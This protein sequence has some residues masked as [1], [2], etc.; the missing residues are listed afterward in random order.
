MFY[1]PR[2]T[3]YRQLVYVLF[4]ALVSQRVFSQSEDWQ[5]LYNQAL[6]KYQSE[7]FQNSLQS[8]EGALKVAGTISTLNRA[9]TIQLITASCVALANPDNGLKYIEEEI[10]LFQQVEGDKSK[11]LAEALKKQIVFL[12]Q[13]NQLKAAFEKS[14]SVSTLF[15]DSYGPNALQ[16]LQFNILWGDLA[17]AN[18]DTLKARQLWSKCIPLLANNP[19][20]K[21]DYK[22]VMYNTADLEEKQKDKS[23]A[24][25]RY[26]DLI[27]FLEKENQTDDP[28]YESA[29][30]NLQG[31]QRIPT[32]SASSE[33]QLLI[34][35]A[36][37]FQSQN[38]FSEAA[39]VYNR[40]LEITKQQKTQDKLSFSV[41]FNYARLLIDHESLRE[42]NQ[43]LLEARSR[44][45][46][47]FK[48]GDLE[49]FLI[50]LTEADFALVLGQKKEAIVKYNS[51]VSQAKDQLKGLSYLLSSA[52]QLL[53]R[54]LPMP[55]AKLLKPVVAS[56]GLNSSEFFEKAA[57]SYSDAL[58][59]LNKPDSLLLFLSQPVFGN[60]RWAEFKKVEALQLQGQWA[61]AL[62]K[63]SK[64]KGLTSV[65]DR[66]KG[67][68]A[69]HSAE[70]A[71]QMGDYIV[72]ED[73]YLKAQK[74]LEAVSPLD[75]WQV[76]NS[77]AILYSRMG[78][79]DKSQKIL[80]ALLEKVPERHPLHLTAL[81]NLS[82]TYIDTN[83]LEKAKGIQEKIISIEKERVGEAHPDY[84]QAISNLAVLYQKSGRYEAAKNLLEKALAISKDNFGEQSLDFVLKESISG[85]V[86]K[87]AGEVARAKVSL[88]HAERVLSEKLGAA[89]PDYVSC[90]YN[91]AMVFLRTGD[92]SNALPLMEHLASFYKKKILEFFP[93]MNEQEQV[94]LYNKINNAVQDFQQF[95]VEYGDRYPALI[96]HLFDFRLATK[97]LLLNSSTKTRELILQRGDP[98]LKA[99]FLSWIS[100][101]DQIGKLY[102]SDQGPFATSQI[103]RL[104]AQANELEK[105]MSQSSAIFKKN[106]AE[107]DATWSKIH[108]ML[109]EGEAAVEFIR[110]KASGKSDSVSYAALVLRKDRSKP[111]LVTFKAG[112]KMEGREFSYY[113]NTIV[114]RVLNE[115]SYGIFWRPLETALSGIGKIYVSADGVYNKMNPA[116]LYDPA[117]K[118]YLNSKYQIVLVSSL[119]EL[120]AE[121]VASN[122]DHKS[123]QLFAPVDFSDNS[124]S[125][126]S[127]YRSISESRIGSL[128]GTRTEIEK[129]D[130]ILKNAQWSSI[131][132]LGKDASEGE[133][134]SVSSS[135]VVHIA[136]HGFF[137]DDD[138]GGLPVV[139]GSGRTDNPLFRSGLV[140]SGSGTDDG[141]LTAY[142]VKNLNF[143]NTDLVVLSACETGSGEIR[144]GEGVYGLQRAFLISGA[145]NVLM[146]LWK[147]DDEST[148]ELMLAFYNNMLS[149]SSKSEALRQAQV[150]LMQK[151][152]DPFFWGGFVL[153][154]KPN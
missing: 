110:V 55:A 153:I 52:N 21:E 56:S 40:C 109:R 41:Y 82:A 87:D 96:D 15:A 106:T 45:A 76:S 36:I 100:L 118:K 35:K 149:T 133:L 117:Q 48:P 131:S 113:K 77:L 54:D 132:H 126:T 2:W 147:V 39:E 7:D 98:Q 107:R 63:L 38:Q 73:N 31:L 23:A 79:F 154:G 9:Y 99:Q 137:V 103:A 53:N 22:A 43:M 46:T 143:D 90:E 130:Q 30:K 42:G 24:E 37:A 26:S 136:T 12:Q 58:L 115:R 146:S 134:K 105:I 10:K 68:I 128:P 84:A 104:E 121:N 32:S 145:R 47:L 14:P 3:Y 111:I 13:K 16:S 78:N 61:Q 85:A 6:T 116:A 11:S 123:A 140:L 88:S 135:T 119:R 65:S 44:A 93:A 74:Y 67:E 101:K 138:D 120:T 59:A 89:H 86:L 152:Q 33:L 91:L 4:L 139:V 19:D 150:Q 27:K 94:S 72:A 92:S 95:A 69:F 18:K 51:L 151:Y 25:N 108:S 75:A 102:S 20:G 57:I 17:L 28:V 71:Y 97:A 50:S 60:K 142:E 80:T 81:S 141:V 144:N 122:S 114:H 125:S 148:Q 83:E 62:E 127:I 34:K 49:Y 124:S 112:R 70:L 1:L 129:I 29:K 5:S 66:E 8:A 64:L